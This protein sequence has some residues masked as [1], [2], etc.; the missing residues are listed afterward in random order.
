MIGHQDPRI[1]D[2]FGLLYQFFWSLKK[3]LTVPIVPENKA[4]FDSLDND[5]VQDP[6]AV[7]AG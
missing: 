7:Y 6:E 1:A 5:V 4:P 3:T 2:C